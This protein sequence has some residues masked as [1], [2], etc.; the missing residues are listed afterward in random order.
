MDRSL[1]DIRT[2]HGIGVR[3]RWELVEPRKSAAAR[4]RELVTESGAVR[5]PEHTDELIRLLKERVDERF[6][7]DEAAGYSEHLRAALD[8]RQWHRVEVSILGPDAGQIRKISRRAKLSQGETRFVSYL[9]LF[10]AADAYLSGRRTQV[11]RCGSSC[12]TT[13]SPRSTAG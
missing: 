7:D 6:K 5:P 9:A 1:R 13:R 10:A 3:L 4:I 12:S 11:S 2:S 8:Y